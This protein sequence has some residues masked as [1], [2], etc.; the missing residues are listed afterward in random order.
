LHP[1]EYHE[2]VISPEEFL[3][4]SPKREE[5]KEESPPSYII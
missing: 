1:N 4:N 2:E 3:F 5:E